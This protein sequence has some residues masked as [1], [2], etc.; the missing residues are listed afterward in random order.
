MINKIAVWQKT[1][2]M[3]TLFLCVPINMDEKVINYLIIKHLED[4]DF[5]AHPH[6]RV[7]T[8]YILAKKEYLKMS[9]AKITQIKKELKERENEGDNK[10]EL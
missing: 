1:K 2:R 8:A 5:T 3:S 7:R 9:A 10:K 4:K 6:L